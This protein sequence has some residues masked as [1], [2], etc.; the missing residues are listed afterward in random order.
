MFEV[1]EPGAETYLRAQLGYADD[2]LAEDR[3]KEPASPLTCDAQPQRLRTS[4]VMP[5]LPA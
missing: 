5:C 2:I 4:L 3:P 1:A